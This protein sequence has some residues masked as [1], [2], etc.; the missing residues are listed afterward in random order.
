MWVITSPITE[1]SIPDMAARTFGNIDPSCLTS[2]QLEALAVVG[3]GSDALV[4]TS[5]N[6]LNLNTCGREFFDPVPYLLLENGIS[7]LE[8][9]DGFPLILEITL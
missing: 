2:E 3:I 1:R 6:A 9:E 4:Y 7:F 5:C 8:T